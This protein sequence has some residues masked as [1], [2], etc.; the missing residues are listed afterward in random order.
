MRCDPATTHAIDRA[1]QNAAVATRWII[2]GM[3]VIGS[4]PD[5]WWRD[6][7]GAMRSLAALLE[8]FQTATGQEVAVVFD[9]KPHDIVA[10][11]DVRFAPRPGRNA[12]DDEIA[13]MVA[14]DPAPTEVCVV[15][16]DSELAARVRAAGGGVEGAL[17]F[18]LRL[19][20]H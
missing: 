11:V 7:K 3:N 15:T 6:R 14:S 12:A 18:R 8:R 10:D 2:D 19:D 20:E 1:R 17:A 4:K 9:G 16:S 13:R 5:R